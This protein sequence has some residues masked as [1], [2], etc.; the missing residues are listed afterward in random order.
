MAILQPHQRDA[1]L[2]LHA[3]LVASLPQLPGA[4]THVCFGDEQAR[5]RVWDGPEALRLREVL[6][7]CAALVADCGACS[8]V[9]C[10]SGS[11]WLLR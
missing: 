4:D 9:A 11:G 10:R 6:G 2:G 1:R 7:Q 3:D 8:M 5:T